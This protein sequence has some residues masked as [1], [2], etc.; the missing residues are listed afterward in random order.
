[1]FAQNR[2]R[3]GVTDQVVAPPLCKG[4]VEMKGLLS[5][6][7]SRAWLV[8]ALVGAVVVVLVLALQLIPRLTGAQ[9]LIDD[10]G[11]VMTDARVAGDRVGID[12]ISKLVDTAD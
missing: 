1:M 12:F 6:G 10:A 2:R 11:P 5:N 9:D 7:A 3:V 8:V 4:T